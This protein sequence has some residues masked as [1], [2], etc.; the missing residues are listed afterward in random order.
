MNVF[1][2]GSSRVGY[3]GGKKDI[4]CEVPKTGCLVLNRS[5]TP[6]ASFDWSENG[7]LGG[8]KRQ[9]GKMRSRGLN[10]RLNFLVM[11]T[12]LPLSGPLFTIRVIFLVSQTPSFTP[13]RS[14]SRPFA[15]DL[16]FWPRIESRSA[17]NWDQTEKCCRYT[18][19]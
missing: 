10:H 16:L 14:D 17:F 8:S 15:Y 6:R 9:K 5:F 19:R 11:Q 1:N 12:F 18:S 3:L 13:W 4:F 2:D 7:L